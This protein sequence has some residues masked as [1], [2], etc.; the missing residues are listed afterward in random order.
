MTMLT[1]CTCDVTLLMKSEVFRYLFKAWEPCIL[2]LD[3]M[4]HV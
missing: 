4:L 2:P 3:V 1:T